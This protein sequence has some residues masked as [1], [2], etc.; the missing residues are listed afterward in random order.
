[1]KIH[2]IFFF[3]HLLMGI[4]LVLFLSCCTWYSSK[5]RCAVPLWLLTQ[6]FRYNAKSFENPPHGCSAVYIPSS[7][8]CFLFS[9]WSVLIRLSCVGWNCMGCAA[10][11]CNV[12]TEQLLVPS[13][14]TRGYHN[15]TSASWICLLRKPHRNVVIMLGLAYFAYHSSYFIYSSILRL[16]LC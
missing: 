9:W 10:E 2:H 6:S 5:Y 4:R 11:L 16:H 15:S 7:S 14:L 1:M 13:V 12:I 8:A 3:L